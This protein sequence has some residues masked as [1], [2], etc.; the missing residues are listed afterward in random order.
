MNSFGCG[1]AKETAS[2]RN[3]ESPCGCNPPA[4]WVTIPVRRGVWEIE[5]ILKLCDRHEG[6]VMGGYARYVCSPRSEPVKPRDIDVFPV[7]VAAP[8]H[9]FDALY[10]AFLIGGF[11][12][13]AETTMSITFDNPGAPK[14]FGLPN[15]QLI[16]P[17][18]NSMIATCG[19]LETVLG[20][21]DFSVTR[22]ALN[23]DRRTAVACRHF[24]E[25]EDAM[26]LRVLH[27][28]SA[29]SH[30]RRLKSY[31]DRGYTLT[32]TMN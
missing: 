25:D 16:K 4:E 28:A 13:I 12:I 19:R 11:S 26:R 15:V 21:F 24:V 10:R 14:F 20:T 1:C 29:A 7:G 27:I 31:L 6:R 23:L 22:V 17:F 2:E 9:I 3:H 8:D 18:R 32:G 5:P 30:Q